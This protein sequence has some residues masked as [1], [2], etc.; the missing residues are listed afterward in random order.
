[1]SKQAMHSKHATLTKMMCSKCACRTRSHFGRDIKWS[2]RQICVPV[3]ECC[4]EERDGGEVQTIKPKRYT[5]DDH[6][7]IQLSTQYHLAETLGASNVSTIYGVAS[8]FSAVCCE[9]VKCECVL[10]SPLNRM[11][12]IIIMAFGASLIHSLTR[13]TVPFAMPKQFHCQQ[14][15]FKLCEFAVA[16]IVQTCNVQIARFTV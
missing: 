14:I 10:D 4:G 7:F 9:Q 6:I 12:L 3:S 11:L 15:R 2:G 16:H 1:M 13:S 5:F 8:L